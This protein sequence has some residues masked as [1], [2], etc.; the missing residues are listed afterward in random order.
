MVI[1]ADFYRIVSIKAGEREIRGR[2]VRVIIKSTKSK[3]PK[4]FQAVLRNGKNKNRLID[5]LCNTISSPLDRALVILQTS[6][7]Y[8]SKEDSCVQVNALQVT[9]VDELLSNQE[10]ADTKVILHSAD[11]ISTIEGSIILDD[12][13][14]MIIAISLTDASK[15]VIVDYGNGK[16][17]KGV[18]LNSINLDNNIRA[19]LIGFHNFTRNDYVSSFF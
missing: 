9:T 7:I 6:V 16:N 14:I 10:E 4:D 3:V 2:N 5:L 17:R 19:A 11:V 13:D 8:F 18:W 15:H 1:V 12:I